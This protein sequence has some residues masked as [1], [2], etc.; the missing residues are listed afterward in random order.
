M[1]HMFG[2]NS[3]NSRTYIFCANMCPV[4]SKRLL[5]LAKF[6]LAE[7]GWD[8]S[9]QRRSFWQTLEAKWASQRR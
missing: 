4:E 8:W 6:H 5:F 9:V 2:D 1:K 7:K 3:R